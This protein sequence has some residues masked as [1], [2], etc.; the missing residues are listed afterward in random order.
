VSLHLRMA[1]WAVLLASASRLDAQSAEAASISPL[2]TIL[3][4]TCGN[5]N[6]SA[7]KFEL[8]RKPSGRPP[9][10]KVGSGCMP[11]QQTDFLQIDPRSLVT[12]PVQ[13]GSPQ[14][15]GVARYRGASIR[16]CTRG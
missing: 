4:G 16:F 5:A 13:S 3:S 12:I 9:G 11:A 6:V 2:R 15:C 14:I 8:L 7:P 1:V 10:L